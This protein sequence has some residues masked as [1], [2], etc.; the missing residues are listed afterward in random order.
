MRHRVV[1]L[2]RLSNCRPEKLVE[3][4]SIRRLGA[5]SV[6]DTRLAPGDQRLGRGVLEALSSKLDD[7]EKSS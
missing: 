6:G 1:F 4:R 2:V 5:F 3:Q 7:F